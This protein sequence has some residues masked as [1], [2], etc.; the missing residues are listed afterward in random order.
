ME[1]PNKNAPP[2]SPDSDTGA[3]ILTAARAEFAR[4]GLAGGRVDRIAADAGVNK[5]MIYYHFRSKENLYFEAVASVLKEAAG[6]ISGLADS[7]DSLE[8]LLVAIADFYASLFARQP[9]FRAIILHELANPDST[10]L[11]QLGD[12]FVVSGVPAKLL[13]RLEREQAAGNIRELDLRQTLISFILMQVG[14]FMMAPMVNR[15]LNVNEIDR[16]IEQRK[17]AVVDLFLNGVRRK[18]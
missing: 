14:Y 9:E 3:K 18:A 13:A 6:S 10:L 17:T 4:Y 12:Q 16:F 15:I 1:K 11:K 2:V 8:S 7:H 5:A